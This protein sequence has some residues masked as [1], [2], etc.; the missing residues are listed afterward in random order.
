[1]EGRP[2]SLNDWN[3]TEKS[4][5]ATMQNI[6]E[7][8]LTSYPS[9][10]EVYFVKTATEDPGYLE[11]TFTEYINT[12]TSASSVAITFSVGAE[13]Y[14]LCSAGNG[15]LRFEKGP[16][17]ETIEGTKCPF[18]FYKKNFTAGD[19]SY[20]LQCADGLGQYLSYDDSELAILKD[21]PNV[22]TDETCKMTIS[23][24]S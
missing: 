19:D 8:Y 20:S 15:S 17:P 3:I 7:A 24:L 9:I 4:Y 12:E 6:S 11:Y 16:L 2:P 23:L 18:I 21:A 13:T 22:T 1:M 10:S 14:I 5:N